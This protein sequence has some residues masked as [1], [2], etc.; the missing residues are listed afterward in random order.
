MIPDFEKAAF[1][2]K[3]GEILKPIKTNYGYHIIKV[4]GRSSKKYVIEKIMD[5]V[6]ESAATKDAR[7][8]SASDFS[9]LAQKND[10]E[11]EAKL[12]KLTIKESTPFVKDAE[13]ITGIGASKRLIDFAFDNSVGSVS[14]VFKVQNGYLVAQVTQIINAGVLKRKNLPKQR[15]L[16]KK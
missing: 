5:P 9:Y 16:L 3:V 15:K 7:Y 2:G 1:N 14:D 10:F 13:Y 8:N 4:T 12:E 11:G 6:T